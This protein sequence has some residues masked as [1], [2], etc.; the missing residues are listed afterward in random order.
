MG[1]RMMGT[2]FVNGLK[3]TMF[4]TTCSN[5]VERYSL[6]KEGKSYD[7]KIDFQY[8]DKEP[9]TSKLKSVP[10]KGWIQGDDK[11]QSSLWKVSPLWPIKMPFHIIEV[12]NK[13]YDYVVIGYPSREY[14]WIM[15]RQPQMNDELYDEFMKKVLEKHQYSSEGFRKVP[16]LWTAQEREKRGFTT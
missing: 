15:S 14:C 2:W 4:E 3:P 1:S 7:I 13:N 12:D 5:A 16:Q 9:I 8:N 10:Q 6:A 11:K